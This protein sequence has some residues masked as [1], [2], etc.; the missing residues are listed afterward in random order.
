MTF[1]CTDD[2]IYYPTKQNVQ[3]TDFLTCIVKNS[4]VV[5]LCSALDGGK[6]CPNKLITTWFA[7][8]DQSHSWLLLLLLIR[9]QREQKTLSLGNNSIRSCPMRSSERRSDFLA[10]A[11]RCEQKET[12]RSKRELENSTFYSN[13]NRLVHPVACPPDNLNRVIVVSY[14]TSSQRVFKNSYYSPCLAASS[15][16]NV[17]RLHLSSPLACHRA[18]AIARSTLS[19]EPSVGLVALRNTWRWPRQSWRR[20]G[21]PHHWK[22]SILSKPLRSP[23]TSLRHW[24]GPWMTFAVYGW[25]AHPFTASAVTPPSVAPSTGPV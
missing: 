12:C 24:S 15:S 20:G 13:L 2:T 11:L 8:L 9:V 16:I 17:S 23:A 18:H 19:R 3:R 5:L 7:A 21:T 10:C 4:I 1:K 6:T 14:H 25:P 22:R